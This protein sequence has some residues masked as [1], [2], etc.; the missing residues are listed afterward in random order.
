ME[1]RW[2]E[3]L[4]ASLLPR[5]R[6]DPE[7]ST[8][9]QPGLLAEL[10]DLLAA[11]HGFVR[12]LREEKEWMT[13]RE[14]LSR[15][16]RE[17]YE[18]ALAHI[19]PKLDGHPLWRRILVRQAFTTDHEGAAQLIDECLS[20]PKCPEQARFLLGIST[21]LDRTDQL[22]R[23]LPAAPGPELL[24]IV[25]T[26]G[27]RA[28]GPLLTAYDRVTESAKPKV[29]DLRPVLV[30]LSLIPTEE[31]G[32][33]LAR[34]LGSTTLRRVAAGFY[35]DSPDVA[36][37]VLPEAAKGKSKA[38]AAAATLLRLADPTATAGPPAAPEEAWP[39][40]I[41]PAVLRRPRWRSKKGR[42]L[43][44]LDGLAPPDLELRVPGELRD[45]W[46]K[47]L[48]MIPERRIF[49][50][51]A[52]LAIAHARANYQHRA[53]C[54][55]WI[56]TF[57]DL[58][59]IGLIPAALRE[60]GVARTEAGRALRRIASNHPEALER[61]LARYPEGVVDLAR[62]VV[63][64]DPLED[65]P[66]RAPKVPAFINLDALEPLVASDANREPRVTLPPAALKTVCEMLI[67]SDFDAP[68]AGIAEVRN[69]CT[70]ESSDAFARSLFRAWRDSAQSAKHSWPLLAVA[71]FGGSAS[72]RELDAWTRG[73]EDGKVSGTVEL[74][75]RALSQ[76]NAEGALA[77]VYAVAEAGRH[78]SLRTTANRIFAE[79]AAARGIDSESLADRV[80]PGFGFG[81]EGA[82]KLSY[83]ARAFRVTLDE[84]L[85]LRILGEDGSSFNTLPKPQKGDDPD[86][87]RHAAE[88]WAELRDEV[89][90]TLLGQRRRLERAM[91][92]QA[93]WSWNDFEAYILQHPL[94]SQVAQRLVWTAHGSDELLFRV[95][96]DRSLASEEDE[97]LNLDV[98]EVSL[99]H[100][101]SF[102]P[103]QRQRWSEIFSD[104]H[105]LQPFEQLARAV[106]ERRAEETGQQSLRRMQGRTLPI[107]G[108]FALESRG[109][110]RPRSAFVERLSKVV[111]GF[112]LEILLSP[113]YEAKNA[114]KAP[115]QGIDVRLAR[116]HTFG[117]L[118]RIAF[119]ELVRELELYLDPT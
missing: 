118:S 24:E 29:G 79:V 71:C 18:A 23:A 115:P 105:L 99:P 38:A 75:L 31:S 92:S 41:W 17:T 46:A 22:I 96:E 68:Y 64:L 82:L 20:I 100:P 14:L 58:A 112:H 39:E 103:A 16:T 72:A 67:F 117:E 110:S 95:A 66:L 104:Y 63:A 109:W 57:P 27:D 30:A 85:S 78:E 50:P 70:P 108:I 61:A 84:H 4:R 102:E 90:R 55:E 56:R 42:V 114:G 65:C 89:D 69:A 19:V 59:A 2:T 11:E 83:G 98:A 106:H 91:I 3:S 36:R 54:D 21:D 76:M 34:H 40:E 6:T 37:A 32:R 28:T 12:K 35:R 8:V 5:R 113:G 62:Q 51:H 111:E 101:L 87:A 116:R 1:L 80:V 43:P 47:R 49:S 10:D 107:G 94:S 33:R 74:G 25:E 93:R 52:G 97:E 73:R 88:R 15:A 119:S 44:R 7:K 53:A 13:I 48:P 81:A 86:Q 60:P 9:Y 26:F 45:E 77:R